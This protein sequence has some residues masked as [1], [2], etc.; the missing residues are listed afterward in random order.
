MRTVP[1]N[2]SAGPTIDGVV[3]TRVIF[4]VSFLKTF[5]WDYQAY[6][7]AASPP[8]PGQDLV[9]TLPG[10]LRERGYFCRFSKTSFTAGRAEKAHG[11]PA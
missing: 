7:W 11:H 2:Q 9:E 1:V 8:G 5:V 10:F 3:P 4:I 6:A